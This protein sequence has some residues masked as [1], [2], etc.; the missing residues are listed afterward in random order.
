MTHTITKAFLSASPTN[1]DFTLNVPDADD[2]HE[3][4]FY[5]QTHARTPLQVE[6]SLSTAELDRRIADRRDA[7]QGAKEDLKDLER[8]LAE[9][10]TQARKRKNTQENE[11]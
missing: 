11:T 7:I 4:E 3:L 8:G 10:E 2:R 9:Y 5:L 6:L 1:S